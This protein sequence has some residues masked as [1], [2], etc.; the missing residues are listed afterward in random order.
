LLQSATHYHVFNAS[1]IDTGTP[2]SLSH[3]NGA[4]RCSAKII[5][6]ATKGLANRRASGGYNNGFSHISSLQ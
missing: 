6:T 3:G 4:Q 2:Y 5:K 1:R